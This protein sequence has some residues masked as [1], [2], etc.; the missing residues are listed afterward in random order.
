MTCN[1][2]NPSDLVNLSTV[3][4]TGAA[5]GSSEVQRLPNL[6]TIIQAQDQIRTA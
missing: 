1:R 2:H 4:A 3:P 5:N 6:G